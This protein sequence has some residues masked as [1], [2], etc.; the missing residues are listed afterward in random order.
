MEKIK[1]LCKFCI[2][3]FLFVS[4]KKEENFNFIEC[5]NENK[6][7]TITNTKLNRGVLTMLGKKDKYYLAS[8]S[9][10]IYKDSFP[11]WIED[12]NKPDFSISNYKFKPDISN[13]SAP[14]IIF[15][16]ENNCFFNIL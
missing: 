8:W 10:L 11:K 9:L 4:C 16:D 14:Y 5:K 15:K 7:D 1:E 2:I 12:N 13:I 6:I 3:L